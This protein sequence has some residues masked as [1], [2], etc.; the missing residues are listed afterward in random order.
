ML[1]PMDRVGVLDRYTVKFHLKE[2]Y[3]WLVNALVD[4]WST[5]IIAPEVVQQ[6]LKDVDIE[7]ELKIQDYGEY[8]ATTVAGKYEGLVRGPYS[9]AW[10]PDAP[11][12]S[13]PSASSTPSMMP[14]SVPCQRS[15]W[16]TVW[17][18]PGRRVPM[19]WSMNFTCARGCA[20]TTATLAP[21]RMSSSAS[22]ATRGQGPE[23][24]MEP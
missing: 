23:N 19:G 9:I 15:A 3:V 2:P 4:P 21:P 8:L 24:Y 6:Y 20:F 14:S 10:A 17:Q 11:P 16:A 7:A 13:P 12:R 5:W 18:S 1:D 22:S